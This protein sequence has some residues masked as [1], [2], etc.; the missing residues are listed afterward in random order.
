MLFNR[1]AKLFV[2][3]QDFGIDFIQRGERFLRLGGGVIIGVL[4]I[5]GRDVELGPV[6]RFHRLPHAERLQ[7]PV[8][9]PFGLVLLARNEADGVFAQPLGREI[10]FNVR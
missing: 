4:I 5:D 9:H 8:E 6:R 2:D 10:G 3:A 1:D 7:P